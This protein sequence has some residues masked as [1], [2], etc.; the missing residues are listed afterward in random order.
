MT[1]GAVTGVLAIKLGSKTLVG[2]AIVCGVL[3]GIVVA[4]WFTLPA[5]I[6]A[7]VLVGACAGL[8]LIPALLLA[9]HS[10]PSEDIGAATSTLVLLRN[11]GGALGVAVTARVFADFGLTATMVM[12]TAVAAAALVPFAMMPGASKE[13]SMRMVRDHV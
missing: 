2:A 11:F 8:A 6:V 13:R 7:S 5:L 3:A 1:L 4:V 10:A 9:Q 12:L